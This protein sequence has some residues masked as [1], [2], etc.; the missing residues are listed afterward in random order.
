M[1]KKE[2]KVIWNFSEQAKP[3]KISTL[4]NGQQIVS[5]VVHEFRPEGS[6]TK[7]IYCLGCCEYF[8]TWAAVLWRHGM[9][10]NK[11]KNEEMKNVKSKVR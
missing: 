2:V 1:K 10:K 4:K 3:K 6:P 7:Q 8:K 11:P 9:R 5:G